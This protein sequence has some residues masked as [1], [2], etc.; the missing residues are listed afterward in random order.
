MQVESDVESVSISWLATNP[1]AKVTLDV[2]HPEG[3]GLGSIASGMPQGLRHYG[4]H[5]ERGTDPLLQS[6]FDQALDLRGAAAAAGGQASGR[7]S[8][9][10]ALLQAHGS[11][12]F[13]GLLIGMNVVALTVELPRQ[14][15]VYKLNIRQAAVT[16]STAPFMLV[17]PE[18]T[19]PILKQGSRL[20]VAARCWAP[21]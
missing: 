3:T 5:G 11:N 14:T 10:R 19:L 2:T 7:R 12:D 18:I 13:V 15:R 6:A 4:D 20:M 16:P 1:K 17:P 8:E 21:P 9:G